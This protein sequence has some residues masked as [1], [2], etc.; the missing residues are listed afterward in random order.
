LAQRLEQANG[1][2]I[3]AVERCSGEQWRARCERE[4]WSVNVTAHH[5]AVT[6]E[7]LSRFTEMM[8][9]G[10]PMPDVTREMI[11]QANAEHAKQN[12]DCTKEETTEMLRSSGASAANVVRGLSDEQLQR[13]AR[14]LGAQVTA[15][16]FIENVLIGHPTGHLQSIRAAVGG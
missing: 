7:V 10:Q 5:V 12:A 16:Q 6:H 4:G 9:N 2:L 8:A 3:A 13:S 14:V 11:D 1:E 15:E